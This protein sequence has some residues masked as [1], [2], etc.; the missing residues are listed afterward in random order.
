MA[1]IRLYGDLKQFG[2]KFDMNIKT[3]AEGLNG[4][5]CQIDG[6]RQ[7][8][9][10][11]WFRVRINGVD[12]TNNNLQFGLHS[13]LPENAV[14]HIVPKVAGAKNGGILSA[15]AGA[16]MVVVGAWTGQYWLVGMGVGMMVG[17]VAQ[18]LTKMPKTE[19]KS[20]ESNR[21]T[22]FSSLD[23]TIAQGAPVPL[24]YGLTKIGS[25]VLSQGLETLEDIASKPQKIPAGRPSIVKDK[26]NG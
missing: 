19:M 14:I 12:M 1:K 26:K 2:D 10:D 16:V 21:N 5:Y 17:G 8:I 13:R 15:I 24:C 23:N 3:A 4:L 11:G 22:Y 7:K 20:G 9:M 6:L 25:K 18:M